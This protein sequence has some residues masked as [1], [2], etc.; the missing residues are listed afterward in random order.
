LS[1]VVVGGKKAEEMGWKAEGGDMAIC[2]KLRTKSV[3]PPA[4]IR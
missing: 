3:E 2:G 1:V 4:A